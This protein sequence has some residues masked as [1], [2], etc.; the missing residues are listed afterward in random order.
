MIALGY[1]KDFGIEHKTWIRKKKIPSI[2]LLTTW[3]LSTRRPS[4]CLSK[5]IHICI[6]MYTRIHICTY[7]YLLI[8]NNLLVCIYIRSKWD[9]F[10]AWLISRSIYLHLFIYLLIYLYIYFFIGIF[11]SLPYLSLCLYTYLSSYIW[12]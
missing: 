9:S 10:P 2:N 8:Y 6:Y 5:K 1:W 7:I 3:N 12:I 11:I 4:I